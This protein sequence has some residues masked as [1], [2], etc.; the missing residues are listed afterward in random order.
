MSETKTQPSAGRRRALEAST[1][2]MGLLLAALLLGL[3]NY[4]AW[5]YYQ[6]FDWTSSRIYSLS[7]KTK[8]V[9]AS[10]KQPVDVIV[11]T[12]PGAS[13]GEQSLEL[14]DRYKALSPQL[15]LRQIDPIKNLSE[16]E[17]L[18]E[19]YDTHYQ[20]GRVK[21]VFDNGAERRIFEE[22]DLADYDYSA[23]QS[24]GAPTVAGF[25]GESVF[26]SALVELAAGEKPSVLFTTGHGEKKLDD[27]SGNGLRGIQEL[28]GRDNVS[29]EEW[30][31]LG[32]E[33][34]EGTSLVVVA[35]P[36]SSFVAPEFKAFSA[37]LDRGGRMLWLLDPTLSPVDELAA[38]GLGEWLAGYGITLGEDLVI[39]PGQALPFY[40]ADTFFVSSFGS[41]PVTDPLAETNT[42]VILPLARSVSVSTDQTPGRT[43]TALLKTTGD[44]WGE[45]SLDRLPEV[46]LE[47]TDVQG[48]VSLAVAVEGTA[49]NNA[50][51]DSEPKEEAK[52]AALRMIVFG[53]SD[54]AG[55]GQIGNAGNAA[56][57]DNSINW[58]LERETLLGIP[59]KKPEQVRLSLTQQQLWR[60]YLLT[61]LL[62]LLA[63]I[64]GVVVYFRRR[65]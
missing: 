21:V 63:I 38:N 46:E 50:A 37:Y 43:R 25:K 56:L 24:G 22:S 64:A 29:I 8:S 16:A 3:V 62:P 57:V 28:L 51:T 39:D 47:P 30:P 53:D 13:L 5:K 41:H 36:K 49:K 55:D 33:V 9:V 27:F 14:L 19:R 10:L 23:V 17:R 60:I 2:G 45:T 1:L 42:P 34:P 35:G 11:F 61:A 6:R 58:L 31:S 32:K 59:P 48:P 65:R 54:F 26:T 44:G 52:A 18:L 4:F 12:S 15:R 20:E 7:E 40:G